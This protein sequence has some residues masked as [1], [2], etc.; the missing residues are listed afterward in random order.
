MYAPAHREPTEDERTAQAVAA[1]IQKENPQDWYWR[2]KDYY[3]KSLYPWM[4]PYGEKAIK[5]KRYLA[6]EDK[7]LDHSVRGDVILRYIVHMKLEDAA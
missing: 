7:V 4:I 1:K 6:H 3:R 5:G 2:V